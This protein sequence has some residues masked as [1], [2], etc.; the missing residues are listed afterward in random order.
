M[1]TR[2]NPAFLPPVKPLLGA[3]GC[4]KPGSPPIVAEPPNDLRQPIARPPEQQPCLKPCLVLRPR[5]QRQARCLKLQSSSFLIKPAHFGRQRRFEIRR[6]QDFDVLRHTDR[7]NGVLPL[8]RYPETVCARQRVPHRTTM[9]R[10]PT[11]TGPSLVPLYPGPA[12]RLLRG[13][14]PHVNPGLITPPRI[15]T[16]NLNRN[17]VKSRLL[18]GENPHLPQGTGASRGG[19]YQARPAP[20][21]ERGVMSPRAAS[22]R[23]DSLNS[24]SMAS[25]FGRFIASGRCVGS[26]SSGCGR[27]TI[28]TSRRPSNTLASRGAR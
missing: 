28:S 26:A 17:R 1:H 27:T 9:A 20:F 11:P 16:A 21:P 19:I 3:N 6:L 12:P 2:E 22:A 4:L 14:G 13:E 24:I 23:T 18:T 7:Q 10:A 5:L 8:A 15:G 25:S